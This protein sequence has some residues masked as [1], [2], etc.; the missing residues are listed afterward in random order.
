MKALSLTM[1]CASLGI[2]QKVFRIFPGIRAVWKNQI[3]PNLPSRQKIKLSLKSGF[4]V[5]LMGLSASLVAI[6]LFEFLSELIVGTQTTY[7]LLNFCAFGLRSGLLCFIIAFIYSIAF[8]PTYK[9]EQK[10]IIIRF[11]ITCSVFLGLIL[12]LF[13]IMAG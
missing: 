7:N 4:F 5:G 2:W 9:P 11:L 1:P 6:S 12:L 10:D 8:T 13:R 3:Y